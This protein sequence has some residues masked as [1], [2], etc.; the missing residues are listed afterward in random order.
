MRFLLIL[1]ISFLS[2][3]TYGQKIP[4]ENL[5]KKVSFY[6]DKNKTKLQSQG[7][8]YQDELG[9]TTE[10]HGKW[11]YYDKYGVLEEERDYYRDMLNGKVTAYHPNK[12]LKQQN[13]VW[14]PF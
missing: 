3:T 2:V 11:K 8:Y 12:K 13:C 6:Y 9:V 1:L 14:T 5:T 7:C 10:K 4:K